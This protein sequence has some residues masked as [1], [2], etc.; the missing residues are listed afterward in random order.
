MNRVAI[1]VAVL[2]WLFVSRSLGDVEYKLAEV[3]DSGS[4][5]VY[6]YLL[7]N[8]AS[9]T[10]GLR[11]ATMDISA[12]SGLPA[13]LPATGPFEDLVAAMGGA[14][15]H[16]EVGPI[17]PTGWGAIMNTRS[18]LLWSAPTSVTTSSDSI[19]P[20]DSLA[21]FGVRSSYLPGLRRMQYQPTVESCC[22]APIDSTTETFWALPQ[23]YSVD[24][25]SVGPRYMP[26]EVDLDLL[27]TQTDIVCEDPLWITNS[28]LCTLLSDTLDVAQ[29]RLAVNNY[30]GAAVSLDTVY[31]Q[32][33]QH[34]GES[35]L[36]D[37]AFWL[38][39]VNTDEVYIN[40][41]PQGASPGQSTLCA[42]G[43]SGTTAYF[44]ITASGDSL[45]VNSPHSILA[46]VPGVDPD[47]SSCG[48]I[49]DFPIIGTQ[50]VNVSVKL[51]SLT[52][53][54]ELDEIYISFGPAGDTTIAAPQDSVLIS[55]DGAT[56]T[57]IT[58]HLKTSGSTQ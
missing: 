50:L 13:S 37:N 55:H 35:Y 26:S 22:Q 11:A 4:Y 10:W 7:K 41:V 5:F 56:V 23:H 28:A 8:P 19:A 27:Q 57:D 54:R 29:A 2:G 42:H 36:H 38:L 25:W 33:F 17:S 12:S 6:S 16:A 9:S 18:G 48:K 15:P 3:A 52:S 34:Q 53:G 21:G 39:V 44:T 1:A 30:W 24:G 43:P 51:D 46:E 45:L 32:L 47:G 20:G 58:Y 31:S 40:L 14:T 49:W